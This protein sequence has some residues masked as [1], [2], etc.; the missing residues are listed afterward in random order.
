MVVVCFCSLFIL[1]MSAEGAVRIN[2]VAWMGDERSHTNEWIELY[3]DGTSAVNVQGWTLVAA[4]GSPAIELSGSVAAGSFYIL[5]RTDDDSSPHASADVI[6]SGSLSN[7]GELLI[8]ADSSGREMDHLPSGEEWENIGG[9]NDTK[10]TAQLTSSGWITAER[11]PGNTNASRSDAVHNEDVGGESPD[12]AVDQADTNTDSSSAQDPSSF[13]DDPPR[14]SQAHRNRENRFSVDAGDDRAVL[15]GENIVFD[16]HVVDGNNTA[17]HGDVL[18]TWNLGDGTVRKDKNTWHIYRQPGTYVVTVTARAD[19]K[20]EM[21]QFRVKSEPAEITI[22]EVKTGN[23]GYIALKNDTNRK[24]HLSQWHLKVGDSFFT[25]PEHTYILQGETVAFPSS[26]TGL[27][28]Y[29]GQKVELLYPNSKVVTSNTSR[30]RQSNERRSVE[31]PARNYSPAPRSSSANISDD[32]DEEV[33]TTS[34]DINK[35]YT[36]AALN[37]A[38]PEDDSFYKWVSALAVL[39]MAGAGGIVLLHAKEQE[40]DPAEL[41]AQ[42]IEIIEE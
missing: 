14:I 39:L 4:D 42:E 26:A 7:A 25:F 1:P 19:G 37:T 23:E 6:Y 2:E 35:E 27:S 28:P 11:T 21:D 20:E 8:L 5:E 12:T 31:T 22:E 13:S 17:Y 40:M 16:A 29:S 32:S 41:V 30:V 3:N 36:A 38:V 10:H 9:D 33:P 24:I 15:A 18:F 34:A